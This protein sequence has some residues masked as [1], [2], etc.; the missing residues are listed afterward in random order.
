MGY[1]LLDSVLS[2]R[3]FE[4]GPMQ[5]AAEFGIARNPGATGAELI[6]RRHEKHPLRH[7]DRARG[8]GYETRAWD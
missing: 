3:Y 2:I 8:L 7:V 1:E 5:I 6:T 4:G